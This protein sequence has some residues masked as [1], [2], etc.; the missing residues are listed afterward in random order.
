MPKTPAQAALD[1]VI[2]K[3]ITLEL[4][5]RGF[6]KSGRTYGERDRALRMLRELLR[7]AVADNHPSAAV[8]SDWLA[9]LE[10]PQN[11]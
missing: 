6:R 2:E 7:Q 5:P 9:S 4:K 1:D 8:L 11:G 3:S 10:A